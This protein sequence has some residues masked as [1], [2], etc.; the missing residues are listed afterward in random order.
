MPARAVCGGGGTTSRRVSSASTSGLVLPPPHSHLP[1]E[2]H[3]EVT[4]RLLRDI[5]A[6]PDVPFGGKVAVRK[7]GYHILR[8]RFAAWRGEGLDAPSSAPS[9]AP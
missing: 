5:I 9:R 2:G 3:V 8:S 4:D 7:G 1:S 6:T